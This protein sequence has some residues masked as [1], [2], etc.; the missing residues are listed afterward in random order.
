MQTRSLIAAP[1]RADGP[2]LERRSDR[3][4]P[5]VRSSYR[6]V[7]RTLPFFLIAMGVSLAAIFNY[8]KASSSTVSSALYS[9]RQHPKA[10]E[11]LGDDIYF[12]GGIFGPWIWGEMNTMHGRIDI[13]FSVKGTKEKGMMRFKCSREKKPRGVWI[14]EEWSLKVEA[15]EKVD[16]LEGEQGEELV[17]AVV[18]A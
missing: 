7:Y 12:A 5:E 10:R 2:L 17:G 16:L 11:V 4:L 15:N 18:L 14:V 9:L 13:S 1:K 8:E 3:D 6:T